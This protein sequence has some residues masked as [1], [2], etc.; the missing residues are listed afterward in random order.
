MRG[1]KQKRKHTVSKGLM[2]GH[3]EAVRVKMEEISETWTC[4]PLVPCRVGS[5]LSF[6]EFAHEVEP[7]MLLNI[8]KGSYVLFPHISLTE[9]KQT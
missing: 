6:V 5:D 4:A 2:V 8:T 3:I 9:L 1:K 7:S